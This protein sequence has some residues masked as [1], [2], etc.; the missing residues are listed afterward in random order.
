MTM[1]DLLRAGSTMSANST[2]GVVRDFGNEY[3]LR[4]IAR[5]TDLEELGRR[6]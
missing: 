4:G 1:G 2:G 5:S 3:A 6:S